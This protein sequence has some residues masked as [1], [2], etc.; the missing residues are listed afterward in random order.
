MTCYL[1]NSCRNNEAHFN[2][3]GTYYVLECKGYEIPRVELRNADTNDLI[4]VLEEN[5][6]L[7]QFLQ[8]KFIPRYEKIYV[9]LPDNFD[10]IVEFILPHDFDEN[11]RYPMV[12]ELYG[13]PGTQMIKDKY[14]MNH[15]S[16]YLTS[17]HQ[18]IYC[19]IDCRGT[20][21]Q[22]LRHM[23]QL[24]KN[25]GRIEVDDLINVVQFLRHNLTYV[26]PN[27]IG[28]WGWS[29]GGYYSLMALIR[30]SK[31]EP[32]FACAVAVA[33]VSNWMYYGNLNYL[34]L[35]INLLILI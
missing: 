7:F 20:S 21:N 33:P 34:N 9:K 28:L 11:R 25:F 30:Q 18:F 10:A 29:Y 1:G 12:I 5:T 26:D 2:P 24:Y 13:A 27:R 15:W 6:R 14:E 3:A 32:L 17:K 19:K 16:S 4:E 8:T 22:G 35:F 31:I 23:H